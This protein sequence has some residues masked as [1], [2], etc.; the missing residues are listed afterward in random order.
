M[1]IGG[2]FWHLCTDFIPIMSVCPCHQWDKKTQE[3]KRT[4]VLVLHS[5]ECNFRCFQPAELKDTRIMRPDTPTAMQSAADGLWL[6]HEEKKKEKNQVLLAVTWTSLEGA[7]RGWDC[8]TRRKADG[9]ARANEAIYLSNFF[10]E[11]DGQCLAFRG[12]ISVATTTVS[13][14]HA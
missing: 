4:K 6:Q 13:K 3:G 12:K 7:P 10:F 5:S 9:R 14:I 1:L 11:M 2:S 8:E